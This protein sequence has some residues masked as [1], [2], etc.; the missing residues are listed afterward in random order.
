MKKN[1]VNLRCQLVVQAES[2]SMQ[3]GFDD[4][5]ILT[6]YALQILIYHVGLPRAREILR[7]Q[8]KYH[9]KLWHEGH[10]G[11]GGGSEPM[12]WERKRRGDISDG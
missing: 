9:S 11:V 3:R 12:P 10:L 2:G 7:S 5:E 6:Y 8:Y 1:P 4:P